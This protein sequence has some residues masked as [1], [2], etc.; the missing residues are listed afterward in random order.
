MDTGPVGLVFPIA[1]GPF[2]AEQREERRRMFPGG[3]SRSET[4]LSQIYRDRAGRVRIE[5]SIHGHDGESAGIVHLIDP[6]AY[7]VVTLLVESR[8]ADR[9]AVPPSSSGRFNVGLPAVG[10]PLPVREW[11]TNTEALG[12]RIIEGVE[13]EGTRT[14]EMSYGQP[15]LTAVHE[16]WSSRRLGMILAIEASGPDWS[17]TARLQHLE[18]REPDPSLFAIPADYTIQ[19]E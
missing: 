15:P 9:M 2:S 13:T 1:G 8:I 10:R 14:V 7:S 11:Q 16:M 18:Q 19:G 12:T 17:H 4:I 6:V 5:L 3:T